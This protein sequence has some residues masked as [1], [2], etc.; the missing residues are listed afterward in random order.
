MA[1]GLAAR[2]AGVAVAP[3]VAYGASGEHAGVPGH[4][5]RRPR[6][7]GR[8]PGRAGALR[9]RLV[10][11]RR[12][13]QRPR[14]QRRGAV[15]RASARCAAEG[16]D[17]LVWRLRA[18]GG[19]AHAG[20]TETSLM[21]AID[22]A[23]VRLELA[24]A[25]CTE[26]L[27][28][29]LPRLRAE[30]VRPV[31]S[32]G[33]LGDP[34]GASAD[35]GRALLDDPGARPGGRRGGALAAA[36]SPAAV[37]TGAARGIGAAT[38]DAL[39]AAGWQVV[40]VDR[41]ADDPALDYPLATKADLEEVGRPSRRRGAHGG[42]RR[43]QRVGH[44][45]RGGRG[46]PPLRRPAGRRRRGRRHQ[47]RPAAV[48]DGRRPVG[49]AVRRQRERGAPPGRGGRAG[50]ARGAR[51]PAGPGR[52]GGVGGRDCSGCAASAPTARRSTR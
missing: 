48:G 1:D 19:D 7:A 20:R 37:V 25:G 35:E 2:R 28:A 36:V 21:L 8:P 4:A 40:A 42:R 5:A 51:A 31:S 41:C 27:D 32:N 34:A 47:R 43:A 22:P 12:A 44:A 26:P 50:A 3:A 15:A 23:A 39:V 9:P 33:V 24:E 49:R 38:V 30:G 16:D 18:A 45:R 29:L 13:R 52:G 46:G 10:R 11:R 14:R 17:V 6:R